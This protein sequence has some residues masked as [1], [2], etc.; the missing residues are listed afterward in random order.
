[1]QGTFTV[2]QYAVK[3]SILASELAWSSKALVAEVVADQDLPS[4]LDNLIS[5]AIRVGIQFQERSQGRKCTQ[6]F[7]HL[8]PT[9]NNR[10]VAAPDELMQLGHR[11]L[12]A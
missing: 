1:M 5:L 4:A 7:P 12:S 6:H 9:F 10:P 3:F 2:T 8:A 11:A